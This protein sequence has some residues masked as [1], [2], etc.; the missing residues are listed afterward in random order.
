MKTGA[1]HNSLKKQGIYPQRIIDGYLMTDH[2][3]VV[4]KRIMVLLREVTV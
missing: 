4:E 1:N 2:Q 3:E